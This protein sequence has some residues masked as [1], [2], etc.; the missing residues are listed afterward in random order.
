MK[1]VR[2]AKEGKRKISATDRQLRG[3]E[4]LMPK[5]RCHSA[6]VFTDTRSRFDHAV[7][8]L[9][10]GIRSKFGNQWLTQKQTPPIQEY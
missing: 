7:Y 5:I 1:M 6:T 2:P 3:D 10:E 9:E 4:N 8:G